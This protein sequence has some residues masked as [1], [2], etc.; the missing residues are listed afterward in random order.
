MAQAEILYSHTRQDTNERYLL[1]R[2]S[3][4]EYVFDQNIV[5]IEPNISGPLDAYAQDYEYQFMSNLDS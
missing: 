2:I 3:F 4:A 5:L 1:V